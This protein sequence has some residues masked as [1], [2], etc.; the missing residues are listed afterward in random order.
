MIVVYSR[1]RTLLQQNKE[2]ITKKKEKRIPQQRQTRDPDVQ[3]KRSSCTYG[4]VTD[5]PPENNSNNSKI[6]HLISIKI[7][8]IRVEKGTNPFTC[9]HRR[10]YLS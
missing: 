4:Q 1:T 3:V 5:D 6:I 9:D 10:R 8:L 2:H 7:N